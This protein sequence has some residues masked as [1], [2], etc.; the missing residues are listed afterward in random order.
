MLSDNILNIIT[1]VFFISVFLYKTS[2]TYHTRSC[3]RIADYWRILRMRRLI[4][5]SDNNMLAVF[6]KPLP[7]VNLTLLQLKVVTNHVQLQQKQRNTSSCTGMVCTSYTGMCT[8][9]TGMWT[10][11]TGMVC[12]HQLVFILLLVGFKG[13]TWTIVVQIFR[14]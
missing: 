14:I 3:L 1:S 10:S 6:V 8:S 9:D 13:S 11:Y 7:N 2:S 5:L 4:R 12:I